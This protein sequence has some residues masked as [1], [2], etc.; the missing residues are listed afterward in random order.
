MKNLLRQLFHP[1]GTLDLIPYG[2]SIGVLFTMFIGDLLIVDLIFPYNILSLDVFFMTMLGVLAQR[3]I[4]YGFPILWFALYILI[5]YGFFVVQV[6][7]L[8]FL[9]RSTWWMLL[10]LNLYWWVG[11]L[12]LLAIPT[13]K[14]N[15]A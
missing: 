3:V 14:P 9:C 1:A 4:E 6:K 12:L 2:I 13:Q 5:A 11:P 8:R 7:R 10:C 15:K